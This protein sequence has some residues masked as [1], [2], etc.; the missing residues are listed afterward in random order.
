M[1][2]SPCWLVDYCWCLF[3]VKSAADAI[4]KDFSKDKKA[5]SVVETAKPTSH[6][7]SCA[8]MFRKLGCLTLTEEKEVNFSINYDTPDSNPVT[9][10]G[11]DGL[12]LNDTP[13]PPQQNMGLSNKL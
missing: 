3:S 1:S 10:N 7:F 11:A 4:E 8:N 9:S 6:S 5:V 12:D 13:A 2:A